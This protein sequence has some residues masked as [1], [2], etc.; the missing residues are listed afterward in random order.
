MREFWILRAGYTRETSA[1]ST[2]ISDCVFWAG[3]R[4]VIVSPDG[5]NVYPE[6]VERV[7]NALPGVRESAVV[8]AR[9]GAREQVHL[10]VVPEAGT[11]VES[12]IAQREHGVLEP[13]QR[14]R[15]FSV[16]PEAALPRTSGTNKLKTD[17]DFGLAR[18]RRDPAIVFP[19]RFR[20][21]RDSQVCG[22]T[23]DQCDES[24]A[25]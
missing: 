9:Q 14:I 19:L 18:G 11:D 5:L 2:R 3:K 13:H 25:R 10:V 8:A 24:C 21:R 23:A 6:D 22:R 4:R 17:R 1:N 15:G 20:G 12:I 16:W 7:V